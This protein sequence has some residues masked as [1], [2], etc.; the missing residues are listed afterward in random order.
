[1][2]LFNDDHPRY[3][4]RVEKNGTSRVVEVGELYPDITRTKEELK[5]SR[6]DKLLELYDM[7]DEEV[8]QEDLRAYGKKDTLYGDLFT[9]RE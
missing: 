3:E 2:L 8:W 4:I 7:S 1:M 5:F 6:L 9:V